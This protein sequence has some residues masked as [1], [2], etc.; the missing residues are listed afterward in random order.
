V[1]QQQGLARAALQGVDLGPANVHHLFGKGNHF[2]S[3]RG[4]QLTAVSFQPLAGLYPALYF[5]N[6]HLVFGT[7]QPFEKLIADGC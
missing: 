5:L 4:C 7:P 6:Y 2:Y 3:F 1:E